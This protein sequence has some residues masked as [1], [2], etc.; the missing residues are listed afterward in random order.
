M[1]KFCND[2]A[3]RD[4]CFGKGI[5]DG[6]FAHCRRVVVIGKQAY[7]GYCPP[8]CALHQ[9]IKGQAGCIGCRRYVKDLDSRVCVECLSADGRILFEARD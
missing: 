1:T 3:K 5:C 9:V 7:C 2:E 6:D 4:W 8:R